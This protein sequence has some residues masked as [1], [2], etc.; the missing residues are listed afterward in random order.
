VQEKRA[1]IDTTE[2]SKLRRELEEPFALPPGA[3]EHFRAEGYVKLKHVLS[4]E[5]LA[6]YGEAITRQV[7]R[8]NTLNKPMAERSTYERAFLQIMNL[9][10]KDETCREFS[11]SR[12]LARIAA[13][14]MGVRGVRMYH[15]Q[16]LHK[17]AG[18]GFTPWH[19]DQY[20]W[21]LSNNNTCTV[22]VPFQDTPLE[23]G[24]LAFAARSHRFEH[25]RD[26]EISDE[27]EAKLQKMLEAQKFRY[28]EEPYEL[29]EV[30][31]H[32]GWTF[33][34]AGGNSS[35]RPR[36]V[37]TVIYMEDGIRLIKPTN[38]HHQPD[39]ETW[40]PDCQIGEVAN[41]RLN[42]VLWRE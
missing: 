7:I 11:F 18:G 17:E 27:S 5:L 8:L 34:R 39:W 30:S 4:P 20:Y 37:M 36:A 10:T 26:L 33:H 3:V 23:M 31:Y 19:A 22:W 42:P 6:S 2:L 16:A 38:Q 1:M 32:Y 14:L 25:G 12:R 40:L 29:G 35:D 9:W 15:D 13:E 41:S 21:P 24:P 28:V